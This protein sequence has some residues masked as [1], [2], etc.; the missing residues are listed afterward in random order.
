MSVSSKGKR[1]ITVCNKIYL[2]KVALDDESG[3]YALNIVSDDKYLIISC[4][5]QTKT[6]Y[7]ISKG[8]VFQTKDTTGIWKRY[9]LPF[10]VPDTITPKFVEQLIVW[11]THDID[12]I[13]INRNEVPV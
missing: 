2:W 4:P 3:Y 10:N 6:S 13:Q 12:S 9:L 11:S 5:L 1:K 7:V 8:R